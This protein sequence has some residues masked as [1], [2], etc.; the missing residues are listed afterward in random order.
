MIVINPFSWSMAP[1]H[2]WYE[3]IPLRIVN[4]TSNIYGMVNRTTRISVFKVFF[5]FLDK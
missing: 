2:D 4:C 1:V 5:F 3:P